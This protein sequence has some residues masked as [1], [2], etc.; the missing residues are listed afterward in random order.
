MRWGWGLCR[1]AAWVGFYRDALGRANQRL[2]LAADEVLLLVSSE[3]L[4]EGENVLI[5]DDFLASGKTIEK[6]VR[7]VNSAEANLIGICAVIEKT[8]EGGRERMEQY[9]VPVEAL[10]QITEMT[11]DGRIILA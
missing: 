6:L 10:A 1:L 4:H 5:V 8:F 3:F 9:G 2:A 11:D 7:M